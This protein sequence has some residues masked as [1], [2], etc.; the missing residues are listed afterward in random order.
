MED[1]DEE[2]QDDNSDDYSWRVRRASMQLISVV[3]GVS[4]ELCNSLIIHS[5]IYEPLIEKN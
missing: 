1:E 5:E 2:Y 3:C 4:A